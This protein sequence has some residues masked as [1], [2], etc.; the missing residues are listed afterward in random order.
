MHSEAQD[1]G[2]TVAR[3]SRLGIALSVRVKAAELLFPFSSLVSLGRYSQ[4]LHVTST[5]VTL[6]WRGPEGPAVPPV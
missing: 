5:I 4:V 3:D 6:H 2:L 1:L